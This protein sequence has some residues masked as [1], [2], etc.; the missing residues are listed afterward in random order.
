ME[1]ACDGDNSYYHYA[2]IKNKALAKL[3]KYIYK[4]QRKQF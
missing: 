1:I 4:T 3:K 2:G